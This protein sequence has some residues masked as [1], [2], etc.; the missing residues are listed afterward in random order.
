MA[1]A[2]PALLAIE[3]IGGWELHDSVCAAL[4]ACLELAHQLRQP[5][6]TGLPADALAVTT[7]CQAI[8]NGVTFIDEACQHQLQKWIPLYE[9]TCWAN[10]LPK[11]HTGA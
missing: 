9:Q 4:V 10:D 7:C 11:A 8:S 3:G 2:V 6:W 5:N 1:A